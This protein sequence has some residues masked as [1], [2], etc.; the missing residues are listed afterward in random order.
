[1]M[2]GLNLKIST[3]GN[4]VDGASTMTITVHDEAGLP[5]GSVE[6]ANVPLAMVDDIHNNITVT[7]FE[8]GFMVDSKAAGY[9]SMKTPHNVDSIQD[10]AEEVARLSIYTVTG[11]WLANVA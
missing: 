10:A 9:V 4:W 7:K 3:Q 1:M 2:E 6:L 8:S 11:R 5:N